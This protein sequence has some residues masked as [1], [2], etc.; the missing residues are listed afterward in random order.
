MIPFSAAAPE[1]LARVPGT[2]L[3]RTRMCFLIIG[4]RLNV[5]QTGYTFKS[6]ARAAYKIWVD[7]DPAELHRPT[8]QPDMPIIADAKE[9]LL[10]TNRQLETINGIR[11]NMQIGW[12]GVKNGKH[13]I[14]LSRQSIEISTAKSILIIL[15]KCYSINSNA[16][17]VVVTGNATAC[18]VSFQVAKMKLGQRLVFQ[19]RFSLHG[20]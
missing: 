5:R 18:I 17:D 3:F 15:W 16:D 1:R 10:E 8:V 6:F 19:F 13:V 9:F 7:I 4:S 14:R 12:H 11:P 20:L 2:L